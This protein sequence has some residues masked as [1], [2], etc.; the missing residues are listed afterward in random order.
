MLPIFISG[1]LKSEIE[2][3]IDKV[4]LPFLLVATLYSFGSFS[5][6]QEVMNEYKLKSK[7]MVELIL[8][9][10]VEQLTLED[11][12]NRTSMAFTRF[13][14][15]LLCSR[16]DLV[17]DFNPHAD[18]GTISLVLIEEEVEGLQVFKDGE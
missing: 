13:N 3:V 1:K 9:V 10:M 4:I 18:G 11:Y 17:C 6:S 8:N 15:C 7:S 14:Y 12:F 16:P 5:F 2:D